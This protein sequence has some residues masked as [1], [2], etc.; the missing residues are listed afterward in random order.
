MGGAA[1]YALLDAS[2]SLVVAALGVVLMCAFEM[3]ITAEMKSGFST[4]A[5]SWIDER[6][7]T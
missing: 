2:G 5:T 3:A 4:D 7:S 6:R 1:T